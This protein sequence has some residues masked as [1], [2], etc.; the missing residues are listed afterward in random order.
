M[1]LALSL[2]A[3]ATSAATNEDARTFP[4]LVQYELGEAE[5]A[6][7]DNIDIRQ[8]RGTRDTIALGETYCVEGMYRLGSKDEA[9]L[10]LFAT[11]SINASSPIDPKQ[12]VRIKKGNGSFRL[13]KTMTE[14]GYLHISFY[15]LPSGSAFGGVYFGQG[16]GVLRQK[17]F[18]YLQPHDSV[19]DRTSHGNTVSLSGPNRAILEYLGD[20]VAPPSNMDPKYGK[21]G[22]V[23]AIQLAGRQAGIT[24]KKVEVDDSEY[25]YLVGVF[26]EEAD[27]PK[28][29]EQ[30]K[31][32]DDYEES[33]S[34][35]SHDCYTKNIVPRRAFPS[36]TSQRITRRA[37]LRLQIFFDRI[38]AAR[39]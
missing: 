7:G 2:C 35:G 16:K 22:L 18:S 27:Y 37:I 15:P 17:G 8:V 25:P 11:T 28:L 13:I 32:M 23:K 10:A 33:G 34:V 3:S 14:E 5:F 6:P 1:A 24:V 4:A 19:N 21:E 12:T 20:P 30:I 9:E 39:E 38:T 31:K 36:E 26:C 29:K